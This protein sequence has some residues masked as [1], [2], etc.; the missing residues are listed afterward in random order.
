MKLFL[1]RK[2]TSLAAGRPHSSIIPKTS[3]DKIQWVMIFKCQTWHHGSDTWLGFHFQSDGSN[4]WSSYRC[5]GKAMNKRSCVPVIKTKPS[6]QTSNKFNLILSTQ[7]KMYSTLSRIALNQSMEIEP[8]FYK[9]NRKFAFF[10]KLLGSLAFVNKSTRNIMALCKGLRTLSLKS[11][12]LVLRLQ[13][14]YSVAIAIVLKLYFCHI[15]R[16]TAV[17]FISLEELGELLLG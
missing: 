1:F 9:R 3:P 17:S 14:T 10:S 4:S 12:V 8:I 16:Q 2:W 6:D 7:S 11:W 13:R 5:C 15:Q